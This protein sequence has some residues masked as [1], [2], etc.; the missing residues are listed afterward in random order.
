MDAHAPLV[1]IMVAALWATVACPQLRD[2]D[3]KPRLGD[4]GGGGT[5]AGAGVAGGDGGPGSAGTGAVGGAGPST[6]PPADSGTEP[7]PTVVDCGSDEVTAQDGAC[8]F[9]DSAALT[10][11]EARTSCQARGSGWD[12][13]TIGSTTQNDLVASSTG[14]EAWLGAT[15]A[16]D[17]GRWLWVDEDAPFFEVDVA[18]TTGFANWS[19]GEPNDYDGSDCLRIL[20]TGEWADWPCDSTRGFVCSH[21]AP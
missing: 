21:R 12:L 2:D 16:V 18:S 17:E 20:T 6:P 14:F 5:S 11:A 8:Y 7:E 19:D 3:F 10:W 15:D 1:G 4:L 13:V 9:I